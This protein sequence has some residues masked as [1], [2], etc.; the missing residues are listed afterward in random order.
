MAD[1]R[2]LQVHTLT[3][4]P[5]ALLN[6]DDAGFAKRL[7]FG[8]STRTRISSQCLKYHWRNH[9]GEN[10]LYGDG[11]D[12]PRSV[13][14]RETFYR[15]VA[16]PLIDSGLPERLVACAVLTLRDLVL[17]DSKPSEA[18]HKAIL[19]GE[20]KPE[21]ALV[22]NQVTILGEPECRYLRELAAQVVEGLRGDLEI[23]WG[24]A[25]ASLSPEQMKAACKAFGDI[26]KGD[27]KKNLKGLTLAAGLDA[28]MFGRMATSDALARGDAAIHVAH[29]FTTHAEESESDYFSAVDELKAQ[30]GEGELGSGHINTSELNSGLFYGY[31]VVD[32]PLLVSNLEGCEREEW[33]DADRALA[34][35]VIER[36]I[37][38]IATV[39]P[40]AKLGSTAPYAL[41][42]CVLIEAGASQPRTL[43]NAFRR[44]VTPEPD[45]LTSS[46]QAL[47][48]HLSDLDGMYGVRTER[49]LS[50]TR[51]V[52]AVAEALGLEG[53]IPL[54]EA[55]RW[56]ADQ[57]RG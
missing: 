37:H 17:S 27:L 47:A 57:V 3:S 29:A 42:E 19:A 11:L 22:S 4:Y 6:R 5:G 26:S 48:D 30:S 55:A 7:P 45:L 51:A 39:S 13:R 38:L 15:K 32:V 41:S 25:D 36:L 33:Q 56:A 40:G 18:A 34:A 8:G 14:S 44:P 20:T 1:A 43:A 9:Q 16:E 52:A 50:G 10:A 31:V 2:F 28:A 53:T 12:R 54:D 21:E 23:L 46:C 35:D 49:K 24:Q